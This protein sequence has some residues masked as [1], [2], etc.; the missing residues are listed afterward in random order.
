MAQPG[1]KITVAPGTYKEEVVINKP[2][3]LNG[4]GDHGKSTFI[5]ATGLV[6][7][8][9]I[10]GVTSGR[11]FISQFTVENAMR[12]GILIENSSN[13]TVASNTIQNNDTSLAFTTPPCSQ[14]TAPCC[15]GAFPFEQQD[16]G[17]GVHLLGTTNSTIANNIVQGNQGGILLSDE[18]GA[19][20]NN[21]I[22]NNLVQNNAT[23][24]GITLPSHPPCGQGSSD[25][26]GCVGGAQIGTASPGVFANSV[27][28]N[29]SKGNGG[30]GTG[31]FAPTPGTAA[32]GNLIANNV[33]QNNGEPGVALHSHAPGQNL[34][35]N[36]IVGNIISGNGPEPGEPSTIGISLFS[37][38]SQNAAP[39]AVTVYQN[40]ITHQDVDVFVGTEPN[41]AS[42]FYNNLDGVKLGVLNAGG[43]T[44]NAPF[45]YWNCPNGPLDPACS[46]VS[47]TVLFP[48]SLAHPFDPRSLNKKTKPPVD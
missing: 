7:G 1:D 8:I 26:N 20:S 23:D 34:N 45:N 32:Y 30:A 33:L 2:L 24:C 44:V 22:T 27:I 11:V 21:L 9:Y 36:V 18:T 25:V 47:G 16:C 42:I 15:P 48:P 17:E 43:G 4:T 41:N 19:T 10:T 6:H 12:E 46:H 3:T 35:D 40:T 14:G 13:T 39:F 28:G 29:T 38:Q 31:V 5:D 37:D